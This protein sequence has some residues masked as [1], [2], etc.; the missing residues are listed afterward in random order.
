MLSQALPVLFLAGTVHHDSRGFTRLASLLRSMRPDAVFVELSPFAWMFR[1][2]HQK[3]LTTVLNGNAARAARSCGIST[4]DALIHPHITAV[5]RQLSLP[6][7]YRASSA[8]ARSTGSALFLADYSG[9]SREWIAS[10]RELISEENLRGLLTASPARHSA[11]RL[12]TAAAKSIAQDV[13]PYDGIMIPDED[14]EPW[15]HREC[16]MARKIC[17][18]LRVRRPRRALYVGGWWHLTT[19]GKTR[20]L[21]EMLG[22]PLSHCILLDRGFLGSSP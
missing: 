11:G 9:F 20:T 19:G 7:E 8:Y 14:L 3:T 21:R 18:I 2:R 6:F 13:D 10:W 15:R 16:R 17:S 4:H 22:V 1:K 12:Y 5:R